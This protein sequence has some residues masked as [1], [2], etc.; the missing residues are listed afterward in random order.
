M[1]AMSFHGP[2]DDCYVGW[3]ANAAAAVKANAAQVPPPFVLRELQRAERLAG[4]G[5]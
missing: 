2:R 4:R 5:H 1:P 3:D